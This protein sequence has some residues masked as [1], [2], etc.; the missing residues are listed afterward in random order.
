MFALWRPTFTIMGVVFLIAGIGM[1]VFVG[2]YVAGDYDKILNGERAEAVV[3]RA[4]DGGKPVVEF[5]TKRNQRIRLEGKIS[6]SPSPYR[7]GERIDVFYDPAD[8]SGALIDAF[9]E[10]WFLP[11]LFGG[12]GAVFLIVG[13]VMSTLARRSSRR[14]ARLQREGR[15][16]DGHI[17]GFEQS[18]FTKVNGRRPWQVLVTWT[19]AQGVGHSTHSDMVGE[20]PARRFKIGDRVT[21]I[22]DPADPSSAWVDLFGQAGSFGSSAGGGTPHSSFGKTSTPVVRR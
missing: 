21:V 4:D 3:V 18:R 17:V 6:I 8:P 5:R 7:V 10:R 14:L 1:A 22:A 12:F 2:A 11:L 9:G 15:R 20:D 13:A 16:F 19:D